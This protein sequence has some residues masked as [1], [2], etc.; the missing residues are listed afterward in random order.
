MEPKNLHFYE[1]PGDAAAVD[2]PVKHSTQPEI[3]GCL[4]QI[5]SGLSGYLFANSKYMIVKH[6]VKVLQ[7]YA[8]NVYA[9]SLST[10]RVIL[11]TF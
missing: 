2:L 9:F 10:K 5:A 11:V 3:N 8:A 1:V 4:S 6:E 7:R